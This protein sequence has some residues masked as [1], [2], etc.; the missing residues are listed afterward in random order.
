[1][2]FLF[3]PLVVLLYSDFVLSLICLFIFWKECE[4][5]DVELDG[6]GGG[7]HLGRDEI[8]ET[9]KKYTV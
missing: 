2:L 6:W 3:P 9:L 5:E 7:Q 1:M 8:E 4:R